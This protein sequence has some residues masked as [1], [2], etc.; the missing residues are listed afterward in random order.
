MLIWHHSKRFIYILVRKK[1]ELQISVDSHPSFWFD[2]GMNIMI[3][4]V[5]ISFNQNY[6]R[7]VYTRIRRKKKYTHEKKWPFIKNSSS[8]FTNGC[9]HLWLTSISPL[10]LLFLSFL[11]LSL[12]AQVEFPA[13]QI[14]HGH[15]F[16]NFY[17]S[18]RVPTKQ[19]RA[20][21]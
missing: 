4:H 7:K 9:M 10:S 11:F 1:K 3:F 16:S 14:H 15:N 20:P 21:P 5:S 2:E 6:I 17:S 19:G 18:K 8:D 12:F 13:L